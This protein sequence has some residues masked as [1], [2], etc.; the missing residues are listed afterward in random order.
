[1]F[2]IEENKGE[3]Y[4]NSYRLLENQLIRLSHSICFDDDQSMYILP[5]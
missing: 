3:M 2:W 1:M 4:W 5:N